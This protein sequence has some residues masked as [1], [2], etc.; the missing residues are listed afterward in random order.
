MQFFLLIMV[1]NNSR[2]ALALL[3]T[4]SLVSGQPMAFSAFFCGPIFEELQDGLLLRLQAFILSRIP[5]IHAHRLPFLLSAGVQLSRI[6][7]PS[8]AA[9]RANILSY[10]QY[11]ISYSN[12]MLSLIS[13]LCI[14]NEGVMYIT[15]NCAYARECAVL[16]LLQ[17]DNEFQTATK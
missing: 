14:L 13:V 16:Y 9:V 1:Y 7:H 12:F 5:L 11:M 3:N 2:S 6:L 17:T 15:Q 8:K 4:S 10:I